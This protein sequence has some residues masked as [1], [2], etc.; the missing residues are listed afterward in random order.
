[1]KQVV[2]IRISPIVVLLLMAASIGLGGGNGISNAEAG[3]TKEAK[4]DET[5]RN[6]LLTAYATE[7]NEAALYAA[8]GRRADEEGYGQVASLFRALAKAEQIHSA[9]KATL[10]EELGGTVEHQLD[11]LDVRMTIENLDWALEAENYEKDTMYPRYAVQAD[12]ANNQEAIQSYEFQLAAEERHIQILLQARNDLAAYSG[13][14]IDFFVCPRCGNTVRSM[15]FKAC[16]VCE[17]PKEDF[18]KVR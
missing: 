12:K 17:T 3:Q 13:Q 14:N 4:H 5:L 15:S 2:M 16:P 7:T 1:M 8:F 11:S 18:V 10:I 6:N 9:N